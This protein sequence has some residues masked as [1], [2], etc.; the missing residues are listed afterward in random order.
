MNPE[1]N[2]LEQR[3]LIYA[4]VST[5][6]Q[7]R[8]SIDNQVQTGLEWC[9]RNGINQIKVIKETGSGESQINRPG[10][11]EAINLAEDNK[12]DIL[13][14]YDETRGGR[15]NSDT[16]KLIDL[17]RARGIKVATPYKTFDFNDPNDTLFAQIQGSFAEFEYHKIRLRSRDGRRRAKQLGLYIGE[18]LPYGWGTQRI[19]DEKQGRFYSEIVFDEKERGG[20]TLIVDLAEKGFSSKKIAEEMTRC[21]YKTKNGKDN[22][23]PA[24]VTGIL[25]STWLYG[26][27]VY[28]KKESSKF[29]GKRI[30]TQKPE[31]NWIHCEVPALISKERFNA[32]Q[33]SIKRRTLNS[34][35]QTIHQY[36]FADRLICGNCRNEATKYNQLNRSTRIGHRTDRYIKKNGEVSFFPYYVCVG[37]SRYLGRDWQC[38]LPQIRSTT[39]DEMLWSETKTIL[40][41]PKII[42]DAVVYSRKEELEQMSEHEKK[43][44]SKERDLQSLVT[45]KESAQEKFLLTNEI[46][47]EKFKKIISTMGYQI[48]DLQNEVEALKKTTPIKSKPK[49]PIE[50]IEDACNALVK[51][52]D[53][54]DFK[55]KRKIIEVLYEEVVVDMV[56]GN[57][58]LT[59]HGRIPLFPQSIDNLPLSDSDLPDLSPHAELAGFRE[60]SC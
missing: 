35:H 33:E 44:A 29:E 3:V 16:N 19:L 13:W 55:M 10:I 46:P 34:E 51:S 40:K 38:T 28:Y 36:L 56:D 57:F 41:N 42:H 43:I 14:L 48:L 6:Q 30:Y 18:Q 37:R 32:L 50:S 27:A 25:H 2:P 20:L 45:Q 1:H 21:G 8:Y 49:I 52:I 7:T 60:R 5:E 22:W 39:L 11:Q 24:T 12:Y 26:Q 59:L 31:E 58:N 9:K 17:F 54:Y 23:H 4:R 53:R 47:V 15:R